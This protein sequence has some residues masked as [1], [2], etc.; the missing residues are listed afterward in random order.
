MKNSALVVSILLITLLSGCSV[1]KT[2]S[3]SQT[4]KDSGKI[5]TS[6]IY[7]WPETPTVKT[8]IT[9]NSVNSQCKSWGYQDA[10]H[11][12]GPEKDCI[13]KDLNGNI[14]SS[15]CIKWQVSDLYECSI[16]PEQQAARNEKKQKEIQAQQ[17]E[18]ARAERAQQEFMNNLSNYKVIF[19]CYEKHPGSRQVKQFAQELMNRYIRKDSQGYAHMVDYFNCTAR[20]D[21]IPKASIIKR[22]KLY[23][24]DDQAAYFL[25]E[26]NILDDGAEDV[27]GVVAK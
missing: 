19:T 15:G 21:Q 12:A 2:P 24:S 26:F 27:W 23:H 13:S 3:I 7:D 9:L 20:N 4:D 11:T 25:V 1:I 16:T 17:E 18:N 10:K 14:H 5:Q 8:D 6:Y 22:A